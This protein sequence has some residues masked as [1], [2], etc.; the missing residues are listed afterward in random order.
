LKTVM[1]ATAGRFEP[2]SEKASHDQ[3]AEDRARHFF[4]RQV[5]LDAIEEYLYGDDAKPLVAGNSRPPAYPLSSEFVYSVFPPTRPAR[6]AF[7]PT[8]AFR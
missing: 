6:Y 5:V 3:F 8:F 4:G 7:E 2:L 1:A